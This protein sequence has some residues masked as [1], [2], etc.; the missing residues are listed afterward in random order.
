MLTKSSG[1]V[2]RGTRNVLLDFVGD[3]DHCLVKLPNYFSPMQLT[4]TFLCKIVC[5]V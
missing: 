1:N 3:P 2:N 4:V 5:I